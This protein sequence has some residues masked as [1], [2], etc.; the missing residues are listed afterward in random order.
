MIFD[1][2]PAAVEEEAFGHGGHLG[3]WGFEG[4][5]ARGDGVFAGFGEGART[6]GF[7]G[8]S[9]EFAAEGGEGTLE[10]AGVDAGEDVEQS[11][12]FEGGEI[13]ADIVAEAVVLAEGSPEPGAGVFA[14]DDIEEAE[15]GG[16]GIFPAGGMEGDGELDLIDFAVFGDDGWLVARRLAE[17][18]Q[19][20]PAAGGQVIRG[21][22][23][24]EALDFVECGAS[25]DG[26]NGVAAA[27]P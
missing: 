24:E 9:G 3:P 6:D 20:W 23:V 8:Q 13:G 2:D 22:V 10:F 1:G 15:S 18:A 21:D 4:E 26:D 27:E 25:G 7:G 5:T 12:I 16:L 14:E 11:G 17:S 19:G